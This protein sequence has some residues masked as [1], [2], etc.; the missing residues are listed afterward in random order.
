[1]HI[2]TNSL[3]INNSPPHSLDDRPTFTALS[4]ATQIVS[5]TH[6]RINHFGSRFLPHTTSQIRCILPLLANR[7][8]LVGHDDGLSVLDMLPQEWTDQ[9]EALVKGPNEAVCRPI[10]RGERCAMLKVLFLF[11][12]GSI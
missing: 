7:I 12:H 3:T 2:Q 10:W 4:F 5:P 1:L 6:L 9:G 11:V 8:I